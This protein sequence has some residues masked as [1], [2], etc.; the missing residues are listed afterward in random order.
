MR[1]LI[2]DMYYA[3][4]ISVEIAERLLDKLTKIRDKKRW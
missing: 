1:R 4:E 3:D 2:Y